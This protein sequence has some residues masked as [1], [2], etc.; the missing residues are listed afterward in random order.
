MILVDIVFK[1]TLCTYVTSLRFVGYNYDTTSICYIYVNVLCLFSVL[2][3]VEK[4]N[5]SNL[6]ILYNFP[7]KIM[8]KQFD[9]TFY[10]YTVI[11]LVSTSF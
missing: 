7:S 6:N 1:V 8:Q 3:A 9:I 4:Y 5:T 10:H 2:S 11:H